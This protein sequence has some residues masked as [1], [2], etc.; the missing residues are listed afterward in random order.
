MHEIAT[1]RKSHTNYA[2]RKYLPRA[3][4]SLY[5]SLK[6]VPFSPV[7][8]LRQFAPGFLPSKWKAKI[9]PQ[10]FP[11]HWV[12]IMHKAA[13]RILNYHPRLLPN[14]NASHREVEKGQAGYG[15]I[16]SF[17]RTRGN[18]NK[19]TP[20]KPCVLLVCMCLRRHFS[21][22]P[23]SIWIIQPQM[24]ELDVRPLRV[25][26]RAI[27]VLSFNSKI[28]ALAP[29]T[30]WNMTQTNATSLLHTY[31]PTRMVYPCL[32]SVSFIQAPTAILSSVINFYTLRR[33]FFPVFA[34][35]CRAFT[36]M[37][38]FWQS[39][40]RICIKITWGFLSRPKLAKE[41][42]KCSSKLIF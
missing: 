5:L 38:L 31:S 11:H 32:A 36:T 40:L 19:L 23:T 33:E 7:S 42:W 41:L 3:I 21:A 26:K 27:F 13:T 35:I 10:I 4:L 12:C 39:K 16:Y 17:A 29:E 22:L 6:A 20:H 30:N 1:L 34:S 15:D 18:L 8:I 2:T 25:W 24:G 37:I 28:I 9:G 14:I